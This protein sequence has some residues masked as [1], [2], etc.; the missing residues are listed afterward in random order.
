MTHTADHESCVFRRYAAAA[1]FASLFAFALSVTVL[2]A[3]ANEVIAQICHGSN[4][5][6]GWIYPVWTVG[7]FICVLIGGRYADKRGKLPVMFAGCLL[8]GA[9]AYL[10]ARAPGYY[11]AL[12]AVLVM[13]AGG[14][15]TEAISMALVADVFGTR[16]TAM[17]NIAQLLFATG[18]VIG[19]LATASMLAQHVDWRWAFIGTAAVCLLAAVVCLVSAARREERP[20]AHQH[21][22]DWRK[23]IRDRLILLFSLGILLY[24]AAETGQ[25]SWLAVYFKQH[26]KSQGQIAASTVAIFWAGIGVGRGTA[27]WL[28]RHVS[29]YSLICW[30]LGL[31]ALLEAALLLSPSPGLALASVVLLGFSLGPVWPTIIS[32]AGAAHPMESGV[33]V[34]IVVSAGGLGAALLPPAIGQVADAMGLWPALWMCFVCS[35]VN[36]VLF[37]R[38]WRRTR[39]R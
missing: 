5:L 28:S 38:L 7:F 1:A 26:L 16:R 2:P 20:L 24:V 21:E 10:F 22:G 37:F 14:A 36:F 13:G 9:G 32:R 12:A 33:V 4:A 15:F 6:F 29:D 34:A 35:A 11:V 31:A 30:S 8:M 3:A 17:L 23:L 18:A 27:A 25:A 19:P 39:A